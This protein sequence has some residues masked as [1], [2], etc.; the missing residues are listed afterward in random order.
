M[1]Q[2][3]LTYKSIPEDLNDVDKGGRSWRA[4]RDTRIQRSEAGRAP[5]YCAYNNR[6]STAVYDGCFAF[7]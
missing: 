2:K 5:V 4:I 1:S 3:S 7:G 6:R